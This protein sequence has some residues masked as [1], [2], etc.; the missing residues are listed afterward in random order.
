MLDCQLFGLDAGAHHFVNVLLHI[1]NTLL[2]YILLRRM[3]AAPWRSAA[4]AAFFALHPL[5]VESVA[6]VAERKDVL[7]ACFWMLTLLA[8][9]RYVERPNAGR[10]SLALG[11]YALGLMAKPMLVTLPFVMLLLDYWPLGRTRWVDAANRKNTPAPLRRLFWEKLPFLALA[12]ASCLATVW[13]QRA[14]GAVMPLET[15]PLGARAVNAVVSYVRYLGKAFWPVDLAVFYPYRLWP[16]RMVVGATAALLGVTGGVIWRA[17]REPYLVVGWLWYLG[18]LA[19]VIGLVQVGS[20]SM[21]DRYTYIPLIGLFIMAAW[22]VPSPTIGQRVARIVATAAAAMLLLVCAVLSRHQLGYWKNSETLFRHALAVTT[23][24]NIAHGALGNVLLHQGRLADAVF[25]Y[26]AA[27]RLNPNDAGAHNNLGLAL[28]RQG[29]TDEAMA[30][31]RAA[32]Q[33]NPR[34]A[35]A[36]TNQGYLLAERGQTE[37]AIAEYMVALQIKPDD[38]EAHDNLGN[39]LVRL[40]RTAE[41]MTEYEAA[42]RINPE[43]AKAHYNLANVLYGQ[44]KLVEAIAE[45]TM[46][47]RIQ[48]DFPQARYNL[49]NALAAQGKITEAVAEYRATLRIQPDVPGGP[50]QPGKPS[51]PS[52]QVGRGRRRIHRRSAAEA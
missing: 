30:E 29:K 15:V 48:P 2:L 40:G 10:Y 21:A 46:A 8:Y 24:N 33:I 25:E 44:G 35:E 16:M 42:I 36:H 28:A 26:R 32:L 22:C 31:Y 17:R 1:I 47:L 37:Q 14:E 19:P 11:L 45:Y 4:V 39:A 52:G 41:G 34:Y 38:V 49:G 23:R 20:Q 51:G 18:A 7:S 6:W 5:H 43:F 12:A 13:A 9:V 3:T 50:Q 27:L